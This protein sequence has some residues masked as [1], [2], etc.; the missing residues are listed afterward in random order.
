MPATRPRIASLEDQHQDGSH[1]AETAE[2][3]TG[4]LTDEQRYHGDRGDAVEDEL[5]HLND[6]LNRQTARSLRRLQ[7]VDPG[8]QRAVDR[9]QGDQKHVDERGSSD[10]DDPEVVSIEHRLG[11]DVNDQRRRQMQEDD[12]TLGA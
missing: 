5:E 2:Q 10:D 7:D 1:R 8:I 11:K 3:K 4:R 6:G 12:G 9:E